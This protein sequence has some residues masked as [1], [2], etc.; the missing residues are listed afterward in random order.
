MTKV[1]TRIKHK[2]IHIYVFVQT[3]FVC[4]FYNTSNVKFFATLKSVHC[5]I[6][7]VAIWINEIA[8]LQTL[9]NTID[10]NIHEVIRKEWQKKAKS[11]C[12]QMRRMKGRAN[13]LFI[14]N[15]YFRC[16]FNSNNIENNDTHLYTHAKSFWRSTIKEMKTTV[17]SEKKGKRNK[18]KKKKKDKLCVEKPFLH[19]NRLNS[20]KWWSFLPSNVSQIAKL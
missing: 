6:F 17:A 7:D 2:H 12:N 15:F 10:I 4:V 18:K 13:T 16:L 1:S 11:Q 19:F 5:W 3:D 9:T 20:R 8:K 14:G